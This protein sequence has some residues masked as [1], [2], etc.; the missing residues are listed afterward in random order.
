MNGDNGIAVTLFH[1][2]AAREKEERTFT[3]AALAELV[4]TTSAGAKDDLPWLK[5]ARF[6]DTRSAK[7]SLR[8]DANILAISGI[9]ADYDGGV[10]WFYK[11]VEIAQKAG[12]G[13]ILYTSP[14]HAPE[15]PRWRILCPLSTELPP[16]RR[17][18]LLGWLHGLYGANVEGGPCDVFAGESWTL[19]QSYYFGSVKRSPAH[20]VVIVEGEPLDRLDELARIARPKPATQM[21][22]GS[23]SRGTADGPVD[24]AALLELIRSGA[25]YHNA[26][27]RLIGH[28][29]RGG[30]AYLEAGQKLRAAFDGVFPADR[31]QRWNDRVADIPNLLVHVFGKDAARATDRE[32]QRAEWE[33]SH[34]GPGGPP[35]A[36][37]DEAGWGSPPVEQPWPQLAPDAL[38]GLAGET[39]AAIAPHTEA[40]PVA[41]LAQY[42][43]MAGNAAGRGAS[44]RVGD[45]D[46]H[47]N[48][49]AVLVGAT[50]KSRKGTSADHVRKI[51]EAADSDWLHQRA[52]SGLSSGEGVIWHL[53]DEI[54]GPVKTGKGANVQYVNKVTDP[55]V[56]DKR[57]FVFESEFAR[58]LTVLRRDGSTLS[59][60]LRDA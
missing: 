43:V 42:L 2:F 7:G 47:L 24:E 26:A 35:D 4:R 28:W 17:S 29:A 46:H 15:R 59:A 14:S 40:D 5:L 36:A 21:A 54:E 9:E 32:Q 41:I 39:V 13:C 27:I 8:H 37:E 50:S 58:V 52:L 53:R 56:D 30:A 20:R 60:V 3:N 33:A 57:L 25:S 38:H 1:N 44:Y 23:S 45:T 55:G 16:A 11:A 18:Q 34:P 51:M 49:F 31:D 6:G 22:A 12:L 10:V 19:S 48:L